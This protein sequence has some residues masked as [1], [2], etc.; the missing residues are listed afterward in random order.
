MLDVKKIRLILELRESGISDSNILSAIERIPREKFIPDNFRNQAYDN[1]ALPIGDNQTISQPFVVAKMTQLLEIN[2]KHKILEI[3]T[4]S[5][6]QSAVLSKLARRVYTIERIKSLFVKTENIFRELKISNIVTKYADGN[7][8]WKEQIP[9]DR[10]IITAATPFLSKEILTQI[11]DGGIIV[12]PI[13]QENKQVIVKYK[14]INNVLK[15]EIY[16]D[17]LFVPN[18]SGTE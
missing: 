11:N 13:I 17:V 5:G 6:Y 15:S 1:I 10:I 14:K 2:P 3:G 18:L 12:S 9:F 7:L 16:D 4:G 8:G